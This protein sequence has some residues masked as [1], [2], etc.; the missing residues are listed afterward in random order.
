[1]RDSLFFSEQA[2]ACR[3][4]ADE[5]T[6]DNVRD[7]CLRAEAAWQGMAARS[8]R[9]EAARDRRVTEEGVTLAT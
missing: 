4:A 1:M 5:A 7:Q 9:T 3:T 8:Q 2:A 6:L